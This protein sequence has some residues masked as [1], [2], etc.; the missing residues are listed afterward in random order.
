MY[1]SMSSILSWDMVNIVL[2]VWLLMVDTGGKQKQDTD[3]DLQEASIR[4]LRCAYCTA[5]QHQSNSAFT[6]VANLFTC[7]H[8]IA[9][10]FECVHSV[11][12][13]LKP[14]SGDA[15]SVLS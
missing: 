12:A 9:P 6:L 3:W 1:Q 8:H 7:L 4:V 14:L 10:D 13:S 5:G 11:L 15:S 2:R